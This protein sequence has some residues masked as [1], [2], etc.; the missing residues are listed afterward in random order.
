MTI[1]AEFLENSR[2]ISGK[3]SEIWEVKGA[4]DYKEGLSAIPGD[5][6]VYTLARAWDGAWIVG[7]VRTF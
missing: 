3:A 7:I 2:T 1:T 4:K 6:K 5:F